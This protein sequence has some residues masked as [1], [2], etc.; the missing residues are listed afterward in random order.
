MTP[1]VVAIIPSRLESTRLP[2]KPLVD[3]HGLPMIAHVYLRAMLAE[4]VD[5]VYVAT[6]SLEVRDIINHIGGKVILTSSDHLCGSDRVA[7]A[8]RHIDADIIVNVQGDEALLNPFHLSSAARL[9]IDDPALD[10]GILVNDYSKPNSLSDIK[11]VLDLQDNVLYFSRLDIPCSSKNFLKAYHIVPFRSSFL[12]R[13]SSL[14]RTPLEIS[15]SNEYLRVLEHGFKI[16]ALKVESS[17]VSVDTPADLTFV[18]NSMPD[19]PFFNI[20]SKSF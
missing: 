18:R 16:R 1:K 3:I 2:N 10:I 19:D 17:A 5:D 20:Y 7:E 4:Q 13:Y 9:L 12:Q 14:P 6:D 11:V 8:A 15:E